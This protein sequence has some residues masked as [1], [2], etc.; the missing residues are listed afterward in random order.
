[1]N[2]LN[3]YDFRITFSAVQIEHSLLNYTR[4]SYN[5]S[6]IFFFLI[7]QYLNYYHYYFLSNEND[8]VDVSVYYFFNCN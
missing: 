4:V 3:G 7:W 1:M 6:L 5:Y 8:E 2:I